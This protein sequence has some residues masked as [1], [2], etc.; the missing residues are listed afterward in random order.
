MWPIQS[1]EISPRAIRIWEYNSQ[2]GGFLD[3]FL[4]L[5]KLKIFF[6]NN[7]FFQIYIDQTFMEHFSKI[8]AEYN[9]HTLVL[10]NVNISKDFVVQNMQTW[11]FRFKNVPKKIEASW[12]VF[13]PWELRIY[14]CMTISIFSKRLAMI[15]YDI[16]P[17][18]FKIHRW[19]SMHAIKWRL[20]S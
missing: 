18:I 19:V 7:N 14:I 20:A 5:R 16:S 1:D 9:H 12:V 11:D 17:R 13:Y 6:F 3:A 15:F 4:F 8:F 10:R 2:F